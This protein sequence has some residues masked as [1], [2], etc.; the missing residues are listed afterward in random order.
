MAAPKKA[1]I[2][3][4]EEETDVSAPVSNEESESAPTPETESL[5]IA[6]PPIYLFQAIGSTRTYEI[7]AAHLQTMLSRND[8][9]YVGDIPLP[10]NSRSK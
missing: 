6:K 7:D 1:P 4:Q 2:P 3:G 10:Q 9:K 5:T 8:L